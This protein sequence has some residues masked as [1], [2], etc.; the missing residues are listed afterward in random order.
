L[1][2]Q[3]RLGGTV[4]VDTSDLLALYMPEGSPLR[5]A[6]DFFGAPHPWSSTDRWRGHGVLQLQ[7]PGL[8]AADA[9]ERLGPH[10]ILSVTAGLSPALAVSD[11]R[12]RR[13]TRGQVLHCHTGLAGRR[14][15]C[16]DSVLIFSHELLLGIVFSPIGA[17]MWHRKT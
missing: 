14:G 10:L 13:N 15:G 3:G 5:F 4:V 17:E 7:R 1:P 6:P 8:A 2:A 11:K 12:R 16:V 9:P